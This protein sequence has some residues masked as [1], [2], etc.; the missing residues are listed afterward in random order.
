MQDHRILLLRTVAGKD[1]EYPRL[2]RN[3]C[4]SIITDG[5]KLTKLEAIY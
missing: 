3:R 2:G 4:L 5:D 1:Q